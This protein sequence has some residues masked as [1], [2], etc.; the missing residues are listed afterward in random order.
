MELREMTAGSFDLLRRRGNGFLLSAGAE[1][2]A[3]DGELRDGEVEGLAEFLWVHVAPLAEVI[4]LTRDEEGWRDAVTAFALERLSFPLMAEF[5]RS[6]RRRRRGSRRRWWIRWRRRERMSRESE[7]R[8]VLARQLR[9]RAR[10]T[11]EPG[12]ALVDPL[13]AALCRGAAVL[14]R[15]PPG[16]RAPVRMGCRR[17]RRRRRR[18]AG[19]AGAAG[20]LE[21]R[22]DVWRKRGRRWR[23]CRLC[24]RTR[25][26]PR[27]SGAR[28]AARRCTGR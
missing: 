21:R 28:C 19:L 11:P 26:R 22:R 12:A 8:A 15:R 1:D 2:R 5:A 24:R 6:S 3:D 4:R 7:R 10:G 18:R 27:R 14:P 25:R 17:C 9:L 16:Q 13:G 20:A 23:S